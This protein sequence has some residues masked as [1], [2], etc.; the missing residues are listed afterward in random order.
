VR[1][2]RP[3]TP[4]GGTMTAATLPAQLGTAVPAN[5]TLVQ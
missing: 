4:G 2:V 1:L 5:V 3:R